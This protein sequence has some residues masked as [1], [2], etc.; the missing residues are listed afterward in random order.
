M[1][2]YIRATANPLDFQQVAFQTMVCSFPGRSFCDV[3]LLIACAKFCRHPIRAGPP[4]GLVHCFE[5]LLKGSVRHRGRSRLGDLD[6][7]KTMQVPDGEEVVDV[8]AG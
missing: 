5:G 1:P 8:T 7:A 6:G 4:D 2:E 3:Q